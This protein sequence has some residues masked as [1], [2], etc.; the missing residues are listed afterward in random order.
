MEYAKKEYDKGERTISDIAR[1]FDVNRKSLSRDLK[2]RYNLDVRADGK[3]PVNSTYFHD[4]DTP[5]KAYWL[6]FL[7]ADGYNSG[8]GIEFALQES[9]LES[10]LDFR[11]A[12]GSKHTVSKKIAK[13]NGKEFVSYRISIKDKQLADDL[14]ALGCTQ[15][16]SLTI[17]LP[18]LPNKLMNHFVRGYFDGDGCITVPD[19]KR[20]ALHASFTSGSVMML[21][22]LLQFLCK[23]I[24]DFR[25]NIAGDSRR[26]GTYEMDVLERSAIAF[27]KYIYNGST[28]KTRLKRKYLHFMSNAVL[29]QQL[30]ESQ[31]Y[32]GG[33]K[34]GNGCETAIRTEGAV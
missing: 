1:Q 32:E 14:D 8:I 19:T 33:T 11:E 27:A 17:H 18:H 24:P 4:I 12:I 23:E 2:R 31:N 9:D 13:L 25:G 29:R 7:Y 15:N 20:Q 21:A 6:G 30:Q 26:C 5:Q 22:E 34:R 28:E 10:V 3:K 16:K